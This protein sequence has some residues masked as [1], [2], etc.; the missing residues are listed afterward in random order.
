MESVSLEGVG[1]HSGVTSRVRVSRRAGP[2]TL[3]AAGVVARLDELSVVSTARATTVQ[4]H[5]GKLRVGTIEHAFAALA[6]MGVYDGI[7]LSVDGPEMPLLDGGAA[8]WCDAIAALCLVARGPMLR[9]LRPATIDVGASRYE[10]APGDRVEVHVRVAFDAVDQGRLA[11]DAHWNGEASDFR[12]RIAP[13]RT[14]A[15]ARDMDELAAGGLARHVDPTSVVVVT[16]DA[17]LHTGR[18]FSPDE[19][20]RHK[21]LDLVGDLYVGGGP[22]VGTVRALRPGHA[23]NAEA[24][25]RARAEGVVAPA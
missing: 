1:L 18:P 10:F 24:L 9:V 3:E 20:A 23:A 21:L 11:A 25:A 15:L 7:A 2:V 22:P 4:A 12:A 14:F 13:A 19:P 5:A 6:G 8:A 17:I 16:A